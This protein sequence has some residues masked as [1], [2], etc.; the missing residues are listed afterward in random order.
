MLKTLA[1]SGY[2][3]FESY[4]V[5][6]LTRVN[7]MVGKNNSGKTSIL[8]AVEML[9]SEGHL[10]VFYGSARRRGELPAL[11]SQGRQPE[12]SHFFY[13]HKCYPGAHFKLS[14]D[15]GTRILTVK[16]LSLDDIG[17]VDWWR[18][19]YQSEEL[20]EPAFAL[21]ISIASGAGEK[22]T[23]IPVA[24][25]GIII[26]SRPVLRGNRPLNKTVRFLALD[27]LENAAMREVWNQLVA[28]GQEAEIVKDMELF[29]PHIDSIHFLTSDRLSG[30][31]ILVGRRGASHR[32]PIGSFGDGVR[33]LLAFRLSL[34][35]T[36]NGFLLI[37][38]VDTGL[39]WT[40]M[41]DVWRLL[42]EVAARSNV[43]I[44]ATT[45]SYD[46]IRGLG[47]LVRV[48]PDL[49]EHVSIHKLDKLLNRS[50]PLRGD[51]IPVAVEQEIEVR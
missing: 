45:H 2:R 24:D 16:I 50:V 28:G 11:F 14:S 25:N 42:I 33:R 21:S 49:A 4:R 17:E 9:V 20:P 10:S 3:G 26:D 6:D 27:S 32:V 39:H 44:F 31:G 1:L 41:E 37:D 43:Q 46:C 29:L 35:G 19:R 22:E 47:T 40:V 7:L 23:L 13:G 34:V 30:H 18:P 8:E 12:V 36:A 51:Q 38:E 15:D 5:T 48:R